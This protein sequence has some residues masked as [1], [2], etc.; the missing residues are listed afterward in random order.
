MLTWIRH[1]INVPLIEKCG[2]LFFYVGKTHNRLFP[3]FVG[4]KNLDPLRKT[5]RKGRLSILPAVF[6][7][8]V[9]S[10][11][12][13][14]FLPQCGSRF[15]SREPNWSGSMRIRILVRLCRHKTMDF[16][17]K[18][19]MQVYVLKHTYAGTK[20]LLKGWKQCLFVKF[21]FQGIFL[22]I[23]FYVRYSTLFYLPPL[24]LHCV[25]GY[26]DR[27]QDSCD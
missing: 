19:I 8:R 9:G 10:G 18:N 3:E 11:L 23:S 16:N 6:W 2:R 21:F 27:T 25:G 15:G 14:S 1:I 22:D 24:R 7:I 13:S 12:G 26:W 17:M 4:Q 20:T 5:P